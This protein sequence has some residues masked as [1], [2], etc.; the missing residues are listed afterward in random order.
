MG[1]RLELGMG[2]AVTEV[3]EEGVLLGAAAALSFTCIR[4]SAVC[5]KSEQK[6][7]LTLE[8]DAPELDRATLAVLAF[9]ASLALRSSRLSLM[10]SSMSF[11]SWSDG[12]CAS[13]ANKL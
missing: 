5:D 9:F 4:A 8:E 10:A 1:C 11:I 7:D 3:A 6:Q 13:P 12:P 2:F